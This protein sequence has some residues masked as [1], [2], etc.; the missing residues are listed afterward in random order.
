MFQTDR[1]WFREMGHIF[2]RWGMFWR[3]RAYFGDTYFRE[4]GYVLERHG[5][6]QRDRS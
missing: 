6:F 5:M 1:A 3:D 4:T 2:E